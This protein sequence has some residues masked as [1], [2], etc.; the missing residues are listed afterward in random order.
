MAAEYII[1]S[2]ESVSKGAAFSNFYGGALLRSRDIDN[3]RKQI[4]DA[5]R[6]L[7]LYGEIKWQK[8]TAN[9]LEKYVA[10]MDLFFDLIAQDIIKIRI[11]FTQNI[12]VAANLTKEH[13]DQEY[14]ILYYMFIKNAFGLIYCGERPVRVRLLLDQMPANREQRERFR[15]YVS[16]L[17]SNADFRNARITIR[18]EDI[19]DVVSHDHDILQCLDVIL[20]SINFRLN[21]LHLIIPPGKKRR[22]KKTRAKETLYK[23]MNKR[24]CQIRPHFNIGITTGSDGDRA[25]RWQHSYRHWLF[26]STGAEIKR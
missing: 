26:I 15:G 23:R 6:S 8:V 5:K 9:Y 20:G 12:R 21:N 22:A 19:V 4:S 16:G 1:Y 18:A 3:V 14:F 25:N 13:R 2:D 11:M 7:N 17:S 24:M 10:L